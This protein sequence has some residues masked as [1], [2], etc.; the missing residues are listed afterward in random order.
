VVREP[1]TAE[2]RCQKIKF[3]TQDSEKVYCRDSVQKNKT[4]CL[5]RWDQTAKEKELRKRKVLRALYPSHC[6]TEVTK[7]I[8]SLLRG[9]HSDWSQE[10]KAAHTAVECGCKKTMRA[11]A[12]DRKRLDK[13][14]VGAPDTLAWLWGEKN[15]QHGAQT[16][17]AEV[18]EQREKKF[19]HAQQLLTGHHKKKICARIDAKAQRILHG[20]LTF[21][22]IAETRQPQKK[23]TGARGDKAEEKRPDGTK[24]MAHTD[25][26]E[27]Q[28]ADKKK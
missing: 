6:C 7:K 23:V 22:C 28:Q 15:L 24:K 4:K 27:R 20:A 10:Q 3:L 17:C 12:V 14:I 11:A 13:K 18:T 25:A 9:W 2:G 5:R 26:A 8:V 19:L 21:A 16:D 1:E